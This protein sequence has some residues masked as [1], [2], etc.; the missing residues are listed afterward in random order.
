[1]VSDDND[2]DNDG[3]KETNALLIAIA[4]VLALIGFNR[5]EEQFDVLLEGRREG[6]DWI[7]CDDKLLLAREFAPQQRTQCRSL[8][9]DGKLLKDLAKVDLCSV[10]GIAVGV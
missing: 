7:G 6:R 1:M 2:D 8:D 3:R 4:L 10:D 5:F 9:V